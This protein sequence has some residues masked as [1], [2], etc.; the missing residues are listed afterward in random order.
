MSAQ[1]DPTR[2]ARA[3]LHLWIVGG[4]GMLWNGWAC[5]AYVMTNVRD[6]ATIARLS[7]SVV[8]YLDALPGW[9][10]VAWAMVVGFALLGSLLLL[11]RS[12]WSVYAFG[13]AVLGLAAVQAYPLAVGL[14][15]GTNIW[16]LWGIVFAVWLAA[17]GQLFY[18]LRMRASQVLR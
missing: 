7:A 8:D 5:Y 13:L 2:P 15:S 18:T 9:A 16:M 1:D 11:G 17:L 4:L 12:S 6:E 14:P 3:P 10:I